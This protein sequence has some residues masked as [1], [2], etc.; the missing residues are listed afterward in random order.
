[1]P[2]AVKRAKSSPFRRINIPSKIAISKKITWAQLS[3]V[4]KA[5]AMRLTVL[6]PLIGVFLLF[7]EQT[8]RL[9]QYPQFFKDDLGIEGETSLPA[10][11]LYFTYFGLCFLGAASAL[12]AAFCP[13]E[14]GDQPN[15]Q[16]YVA[17]ATSLE[18]PVLAKA[19]F[20]DVL[21][22]H[23]DNEYDEARPENPEYP[24]DLEGDFHSLMEDMYSEYDIGD[25]SEE[26]E[27][28]PEVVTPTGY[29]D[30]TEFARMLWTNPRVV[31]VYTLPFFDL[32]P[33]FAKDI[34]FV[35][36]KALDHTKFRT[37]VAIACLYSLGFGLLI[38]PTVR[39]FVQ[40]TYRLILGG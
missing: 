31:W 30:F 19:S 1:M 38:V 11:N 22:L 25:L 28:P 20:R 2:N 23:F 6:V 27:G 4:G 24:P 17:N 36:Y 12:F 5:P 33:K 16:R 3:K 9:F 18:T 14:I 37:R 32:A 15:Q 26:E 7:N 8:E 21:N 40:L 13:R 35:K 39:V 29:L 34:A 10:S